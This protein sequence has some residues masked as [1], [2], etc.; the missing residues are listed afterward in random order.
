MIWL[1]SPIKSGILSLQSLVREDNPGHW[2]HFYNSEQSRTI[3]PLLINRR[4]WFIHLRGPVTT[5]PEMPRIAG[6][7]QN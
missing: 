5:A 1:E 6:A 3:R 2:L 4:F 7:A